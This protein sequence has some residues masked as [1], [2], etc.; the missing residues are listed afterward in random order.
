M[1]NIWDVNCILNKVIGM[2]H[3]QHLGRAWSVPLWVCQ[4]YREWFGSLV[5]FTG[6]R[7]CEVG[8]LI[9]TVIYTGVKNPICFTDSKP[10][11]LGGINVPKVFF[12]AKNIRKNT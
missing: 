6:L 2:I 4:A 11:F 7:G 12:V 9:L 8:E 3:T 1:G 10:I 5:S